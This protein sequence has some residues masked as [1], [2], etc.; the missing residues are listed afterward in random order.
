MFFLRIVLLCVGAAVVYGEIHDQITAHL[1]VE[2]FSVGHPPIFHTDNPT[3]LAI[4]WG[5]IATWW[6]GLILGLPL[7]AAARW[8]SWPKWTMTQLIRPVVI[9][10]AAS[11]IVAAISGFTGWRLAV[12]NQ[13]TLEDFPQIPQNIVPF[14]F[15][16]LFTHLASYVMGFCGGLYIILQTTFLRFKHA[17]RVAATAA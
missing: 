11:A 17:R 13:W 1:C 14:F 9:L 10:M 3:L 6:V 16:D 12:A 5:F 4:G 2:Y 8:G 15:A 7:A